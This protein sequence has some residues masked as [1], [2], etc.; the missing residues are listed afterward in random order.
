MTP[1]INELVQEVCYVL[2]N[3]QQDLM[4]ADGHQYQY[5]MGDPRAVRVLLRFLA[6]RL[7]DESRFK[8]IPDWT[9]LKDEILKAAVEPNGN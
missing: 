6:Y 2:R 9:G 1:P 8:D 4:L 3:T 7:F 5:D